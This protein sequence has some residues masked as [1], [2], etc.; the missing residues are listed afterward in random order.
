MCD[1]CVEVCVTVV[2]VCE[3]GREGRGGGGW[4]GKGGGAGGGGERERE[5][6]RERATER[7]T[8]GLRARKKAGYGNL[9]TRDDY[10]DD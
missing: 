1:V 5:R 6:E 2:L 7:V 4:G 9:L 3:E 8:K 10:L